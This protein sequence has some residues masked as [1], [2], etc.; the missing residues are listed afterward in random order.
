MEVH[1]GDEDEAVDNDSEAEVSE[2]VEDKMK[3]LDLSQVSNHFSLYQLWV[4]RLIQRM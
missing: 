2:R 3:V 4:Q 1:V